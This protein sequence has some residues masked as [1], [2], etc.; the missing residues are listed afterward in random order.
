MANDSDHKQTPNIS[1][2]TACHPHPSVLRIEW[3]STCNNARR[4]GYSGAG[5]SIPILGADKHRP[6][7]PPLLPA[8]S[9]LR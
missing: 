7:P 2:G 3:I 1:R 9:D 6:Y 4:S 8:E 5:N